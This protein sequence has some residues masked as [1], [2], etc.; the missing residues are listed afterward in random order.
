MKE[1]TYTSGV[2]E[3][4]PEVN[5]SKEGNKTKGFGAGL[6]LGLIIGAT[7]LILG[8]IVEGIFLTK[9]L[10]WESAVLDRTTAQKIALIKD[11]IDKY[12]YDYDAEEVTPTTVEDMRVAILDGI[13]TSLND[14]YSD[15]YTAEELEAAIVSNQGY[16]YGVGAYI[17]EG[18]D[19]YPFFSGIMSETPA[20]EVGL[21]DGDI[22]IAIDD[23]SAY[24]MS[25]EETVSR[26]KGDNGTVVHLTIAR[27]G[28]SDYLEFDVTRGPVASVTVASKMLDDS[29]G[30]IGIEEFDGVTV[31][32]FNE[33]LTELK[34]QGA[35][36]IILDLRSNLGGLVN[37]AV[38]IARRILPE[39]VVVYEMDVNGKRRD[40]YCDGENELDIPLVVLV[41]QYS[42]SASEILAGAIK[43]YEKGTLVGVTTFG[44]GIVQDTKMFSDGS[45]LKLTISAYY[46]PKGINIQGTGIV[47]DV[48]AELDIDKYYDERID[49]QLNKAIDVIKEQIK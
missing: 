12:Y 4:A 32:Q 29:I 15:Y 27:T 10:S 23:V 16:Y 38:E 26:V 7:V 39:G 42:A 44:K 3:N 30:Y 37:S 21:R 48:I 25:L 20:E 2:I 17:S 41:N 22:I 45:A 24:G 31:D 18:T 40:Y 49:T 34:G 13:V 36:G 47:P 43:D 5:Q 11:T 35:K 33:A 6:G 9:K 19:G 14:P 8:L 1:N 28:E 46:S